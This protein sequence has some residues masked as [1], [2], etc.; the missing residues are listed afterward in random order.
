MHLTV[1]QI[2]R[3][4]VRA[5]HATVFYSLVV[6]HNQNFQLGPMYGIRKNILLHII[7]Y[8]AL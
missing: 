5:L 3:V 4:F 6:P 2:Q 7:K 1:P 8:S